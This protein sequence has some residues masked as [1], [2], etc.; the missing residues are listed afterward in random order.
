MAYN[1]EKATF[2]GHYNAAQD[3]ALKLDVPD[4]V[5]VSAEV[6]FEFYRDNFALKVTQVNAKGEAVP[7]CQIFG[8]LFLDDAD[9]RI[10]IRAQP[11]LASEDIGITLFEWQNFNSLK[12]DEWNFAVNDTWLLAGVNSLQE[13]Y[14][15]S[16]VN[17]KNIIDNR[18]IPPLT[19]MGRELAGLALAGY[20]EASGHP[21]LGKAYVPSP[22][23]EGKAK[24]L[25]LVDYDN[26]L[27]PLK[28]VGDAKAF[29]KKA[30]F[31][32]G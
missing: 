11:Q 30:G 28:T 26:G 9:R 4:A 19:I 18:F 15:A 27:S 3:K 23:K 10:S 7:P 16:L 17:E 1:E 21:A 32:I 13:F 2:I 8:R 14:P 25:S 22:G 31:E 6:A 20:Q 5:R 12:L 29:F 24:S